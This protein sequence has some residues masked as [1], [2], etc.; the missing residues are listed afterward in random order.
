MIREDEKNSS[1]VPP[2]TCISEAPGFLKNHKLSS[3]K[4]LMLTSYVAEALVF[5][6]SSL[7][8]C[9]S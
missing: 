4:L 1:G 5:P 2:A 6:F 9:K 7:F 3:V 8:I